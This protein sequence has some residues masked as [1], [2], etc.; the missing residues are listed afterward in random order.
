MDRQRNH[1]LRDEG[2]WII[3]DSLAGRVELRFAR[4]ASDDDAVAA[5]CAGGLDDGAFEIS[6]HLLADLVVAQPEGLDDWE[7]RLFGEI[8]ANQPGCKRVDR[9][10]VGG[11]RADA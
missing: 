1:R 6:Q 5:G 4:L 2:R 10:V 8:V 9:L 7:N 3:D 11:S